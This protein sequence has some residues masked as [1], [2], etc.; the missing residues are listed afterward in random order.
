MRL[1]I[2]NFKLAWSLTKIHVNEFLIIIRT[3]LIIIATNLGKFWFLTLAGGLSV[4][5]RVGGRVFW[6]ELAVICNLSVLHLGYLW[7]ELLYLLNSDILSCLG[8]MQISKLENVRREVMD[9]ACLFILHTDV[10]VLVKLV[11]DLEQLF[12]LLSPLLVV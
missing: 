4:F 5:F 6:W 8:D 1:L 3:F 7:V 9:I 11:H 12:E 10:N 2:K